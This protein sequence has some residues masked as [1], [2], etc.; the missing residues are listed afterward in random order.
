[1]KKKIVLIGNGMTGFRFCEKFV[2]A[3][4]SADH[5]LLVFGEENIPAYD[6]V[7][8]TSF[9]TGTTA[10]ELLLAPANWYADNQITL[11]SGDRI[12][13]INRNEKK[14]IT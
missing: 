10:D 1:M 5:E 4:M 3:G 2:E 6:R 14:T 12:A 13:A 7:H 8:L 9:Y 11:K